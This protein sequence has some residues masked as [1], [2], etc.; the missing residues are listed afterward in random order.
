MH[1]GESDASRTERRRAPRYRYQAGLEIEWGSARLKAV[2]L[3]TSAQ[4]EC[5][6]N[7]RMSF[8]LARDFARALQ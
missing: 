3:E 7:R 4:A 2:A 8:G 1:I 5:L 6:S